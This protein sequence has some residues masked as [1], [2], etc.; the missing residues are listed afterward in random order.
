MPQIFVAGN[1]LYIY[2][3]ADIQKSLMFFRVLQLRSLSLDLSLERSIVT[4]P[5]G[6]SW[7]RHTVGFSGSKGNHR[8][9]AAL[10]KEIS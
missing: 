6:D 7:N 10:A 8:E 9:D 5:L 4:G 3:G 2:R 1:W